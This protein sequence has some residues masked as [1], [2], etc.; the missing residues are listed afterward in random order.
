[1]FKG[2]LELE[3]YLLFLNSKDATTLCKFRCR[4]H[5]LPVNNNRFD[6]DMSQD[7]ICTLCL[8]DTGGES[9]FIFVCPFFLEERK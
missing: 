8:S 9:R 4:S 5:S 7:D 2:L 6:S 1:M 3:K